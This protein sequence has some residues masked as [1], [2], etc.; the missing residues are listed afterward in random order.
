MRSMASQITSIS[1]ACS[2]VCWVADQRKHQSSASLAFVRE[3]HQWAVDS[4]HKG[5]VKR[6]KLPFDGVI[7]EFKAP[8]SCSTIVLLFAIIIPNYPRYVVLSS[9]QNHWWCLQI[10][11]WITVI[12]KYASF[13]LRMSRLRLCEIGAKYDL[14]TP[15]TKSLPCPAQYW[16]IDNLYATRM[17]HM[18]R[19]LLYGLALVDFVNSLHAMR[20]APVTVQLPW[21]IWVHTGKP[22]GT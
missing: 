13:S 18:V 9:W 16:Y 19:A 1:I 15:T 22:N 17:K 5:P 11:Q 7:I 3:I 8:Q 2:T 14:A 4:P 6:K 10:E 21:R 20:I 12:E